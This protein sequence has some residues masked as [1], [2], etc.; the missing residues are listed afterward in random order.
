MIWCDLNSEPYRADE[1]AF[2]VARV[3]EHLADN[4]EIVTP[5]DTWGDVGAASG[6]LLLLAAEFAAAKNYGTGPLTLFSASSE[7]GTRAALLAYDRWGIEQGRP[8]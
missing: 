2:T 1:L 5:A 7:G 6:P 4:V 8:S 3:R